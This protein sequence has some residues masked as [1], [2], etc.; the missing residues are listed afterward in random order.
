MVALYEKL[1]PQS[2]EEFVGF[3]EV[4]NRLTALNTAVGWDGQVFW[5]TGLSG[6]GKTTLARIIAKSI[7]TDLDTEEVDAADVSMEVLRDW[8]KRCHYFP[9]R[10]AYSFIVN[11]AH[12]LSTKV[13]SRLQT[14]LETPAVQKRGTFLFTTTDRGQ[15]LLFDTKFDALP[16]LSRAI[17]VELKPSDATLVALSLQL[18]SVG[19]TLGYDLPPAAYED[20]LAECRGN[21]RESLQKIASGAIGAVA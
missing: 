15:Q 2:I 5:I 6:T 4:I 16:F 17:K 14:L 12:T 1:R 19:S 9:Q 13:I 3:S 20:L 18:A 11:E 21:M 8:E 7:S 10:E